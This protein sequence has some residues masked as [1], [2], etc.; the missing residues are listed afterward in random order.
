MKCFFEY[1]IPSNNSQLLLETSNSDDLVFAQL[2]PNKLPLL[3]SFASN[4]KIFFL[5]TNITEKTI[6][7]IS[8]YYYIITNINDNFSP[9]F[10]Y[11]SRFH[12]IYFPNHWK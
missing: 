3:Y 10:L 9:I 8:I 4:I 7:I 5:I 6:Y 12:C 1:Q 2:D 11:I